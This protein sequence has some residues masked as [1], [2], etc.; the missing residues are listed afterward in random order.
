MANKNPENQITSDKR[1]QMPPRGRN[2]R[3]LI[4]EAIKEESLLMANPDMDN[5]EVEKCFFKHV[6]KQAANPESEH[7]G[8]CLKL[9]ADR[10]WAAL[11]PSSEMIEWTHDT[12]ASIPDQASQIMTGISKSKIPPDVGISLITAM[13]SVLKIEEVTEIK[14]RLSEMEKALGIS[15]E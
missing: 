4:L 10:G 8:L 5:S 11:K 15:N 13:A 14:D 6:A 1:A 2:K 12:A 7:F 3:T 9:L